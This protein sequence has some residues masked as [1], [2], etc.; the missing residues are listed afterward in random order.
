MYTATA[1]HIRSCRHLFYFL[2][3]SFVKISSPRKR[4]RS[5]ETHFTIFFSSLPARWRKQNNNNNEKELRM[6]CLFHAIVFIFIFIF[7][8]LSRGE[9]KRRKYF[10][11]IFGGRTSRVTLW[12]HTKMKGTKCT[13]VS[14]ARCR[15]WQSFVL[16]WL[17]LLLFSPVT[18][19]G[20][21]TC[22][23]LYQICVTSKCVASKLAFSW[24][25]WVSSL[26]LL[27]LGPSWD[28]PPWRKST[29]KF[30]TC[31]SS[32]ALLRVFFFMFPFDHFYEGGKVWSK[33]DVNFVFSALLVSL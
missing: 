13:V 7:L 21:L 3:S 11:K 8:F 14:K 23:P 9:K 33:Q 31:S 5:E 4:A 25:N 1:V 27:V 12:L 32:C 16:C 17:L 10:Q 22:V 28:S 24:L 29:N 26:T 15:A 30:Q 2:K 18:P 19:S 6:F 20:S